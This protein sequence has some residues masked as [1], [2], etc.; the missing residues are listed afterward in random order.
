[1]TSL[2]V[3]SRDE[4]GA[5]PPTS[6]YTP[7]P[8]ALRRAI[9]HHTVAGTVA[10]EPG[11]PGQGWWNMVTEGTATKDVRDALARWQEAHKNAMDAERTNMRRIQHFHFSRGFIDIGYHFVIYPS[12]RIYAG[13][14][15]TAYGAHTINGNAEIG[16]SFAGNMEIEKPTPKAL[17]SYERLIEKLGISPR[18]VRGHYRVPGNATACPGKNLKSVLNL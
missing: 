15:V 9:V 1:M 5:Q 12:G 16:I 8:Q 17:D 2:V 4:W 11:R 6:G 14:P 7:R 13:R 18:N 3:H 10:P